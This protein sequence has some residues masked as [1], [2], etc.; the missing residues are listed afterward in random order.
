MTVLEAA[1]E[2]TV[3]AGQGVISL[4]LQAQPGPLAPHWRAEVLPRGGT[5]DTVDQVGHA[6]RTATL[7]GDAR[8]QQPRLE[9]D[10]QGGHL[11]TVPDARQ[12][13]LGPAYVADLE[14]AGSDGDAGLDDRRRAV[15]V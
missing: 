4:D 8:L 5:Q 3:P 13:C 11:E 1:Q 15:R 9:L 2:V 12:H 10:G 7:L 14:A 6:L